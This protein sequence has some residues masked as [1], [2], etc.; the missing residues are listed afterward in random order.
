MHK[1][2]GE[3]KYKNQKKKK[4]AIIIIFN[5]LKIYHHNDKDSNKTI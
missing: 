2:E 3:N 4:D 5:R 1:K